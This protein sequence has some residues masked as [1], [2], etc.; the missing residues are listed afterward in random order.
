[1]D[2]LFSCLVYACIYMFWLYII[3]ERT[4]I[5]LVFSSFGMVRNLMIISYLL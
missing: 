4:E 3:A 2:K 5:Q 1:M